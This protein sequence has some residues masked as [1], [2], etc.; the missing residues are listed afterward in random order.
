M[1]LGAILTCTAVAAIASIVNLF[2]RPKQDKVI[3]MEIQLPGNL[4]IISLSTNKGIVMNFIIDSGSNISHI[5]SEY[6]DILESETVRT[7][8]NGEVAGLGANNIGVTLCKTELKDTLGNKYD[9]TLSVSSQLSEVAKTIE[10]NT[11]V[12]V[13]GLLGTDFLKDYKYV[14]DFKELVAYSKK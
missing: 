2:D 12:K 5:C 13:H 10:Y 11:G 4:P 8:D 3:P 14:I 6:F 7:Y 9:M 1:I